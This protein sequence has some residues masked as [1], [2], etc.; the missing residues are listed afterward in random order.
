MNI[1]KTFIIGLLFHRTCNPQMDN[2]I[3]NPPLAIET[4]PLLWYVE[5]SFL[6]LEVVQ[7]SLQCFVK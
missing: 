1:L 6:A 5:A 7:I 3:I 4:T 2:M